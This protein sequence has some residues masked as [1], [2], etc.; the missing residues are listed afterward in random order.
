MIMIFFF[1]S[2]MKC[3]FWKSVASKRG[4]F[5]RSQIWES[6]PDVPGL[7]K[8]LEAGYHAYPQTPLNISPLFIS[9]VGHTAVH[10]IWMVPT[11]YWR[12]RHLCLYLLKCFCFVF[13]FFTIWIHFPRSGVAC[14][15]RRCFCQ[16]MLVWLCCLLL[17][18]EVIP[19]HRASVKRNLS[20]MAFY[21]K[22]R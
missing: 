17:L 20:L 3:L 9:V 8:G 22:K 15:W 16:R 18:L 13:F 5:C 12:N 19:K 21:C 7:D 6:H 4:H 1:L 2:L 10:E 11:L 14:L